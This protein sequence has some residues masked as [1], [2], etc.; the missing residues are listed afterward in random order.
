[1]VGISSYIAS[2]ELKIAQIAHVNQLSQC[3]NSPCIY[4]D[5]L[6]SSSIHTSRQSSIF[7]DNVVLQDCNPGYHL[8]LVTKR[9]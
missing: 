6:F 8:L 7:V 1:M 3:L 2:K 9:K 4:D 5:A